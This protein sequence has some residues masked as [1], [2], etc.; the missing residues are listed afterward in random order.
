MNQVRQLI[1]ALIRPYRKTGSTTVRFA[2]PMLALVAAILGAG[3]VSNSQESQIRLEASTAT[4][5]AGQPLAVNVYVA[6]H[7]PVNAVDIKVRIPANVKITA[8]DTGESVIT[9]W[10]EQPKVSN[11]VVLL[12]GGT[13]RKGFLGEHLIATI[14]AE[15]VSSGLAEFRVTDAL[16]LAGDGSGSKVT[17]D[18]NYTGASLYIANADGTFNTRSSVGLSGAVAVIV[19]TDIDGDGQVTLADISRFMV[20]WTTQSSMYDFNNDGRMTFRDF[21]IILADSFLR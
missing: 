7:V 13:Y 18:P 16:L 11:H 21:G 9:L 2:F 15:A 1:S 4:V 12:R 6:A 17:L 8:I 10:T 14:N 19:V 3:A 5:E 20:G